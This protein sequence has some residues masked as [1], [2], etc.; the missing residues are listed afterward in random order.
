MIENLTKFLLIVIQIY[1]VHL[2]LLT[3]L[4]RLLAVEFLELF[5]TDKA[6]KDI[7]VITFLIV[8]IIIIIA[9]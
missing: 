4:N 5:K 6:K 2:L 3:I 1:L 8:V 9:H 7:I